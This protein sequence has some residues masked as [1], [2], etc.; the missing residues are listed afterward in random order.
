MKSWIKIK[1]IKIR[2]TGTLSQDDMHNTASS[3]RLPPTVC[4]CWVPKGFAAIDGF[5][6]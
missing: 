3:Q 1:E 4:L 6:P 2:G 5:P